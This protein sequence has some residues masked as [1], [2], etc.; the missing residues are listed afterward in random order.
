MNH[1]YLIVSLAAGALAAAVI[2]CV[3]GIVRAVKMRGVERWAMISGTVELLLGAVYPAYVL[4]MFLKSRSY[5][6]ESENLWLANPNSTSTRLV[7]IVCVLLAALFVV[8][9]CSIRKKGTARNL[10]CIFLALF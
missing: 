9:L 10:F 1:F 3:F 4:I 8:C 7:S 6:L 2:A 5:L